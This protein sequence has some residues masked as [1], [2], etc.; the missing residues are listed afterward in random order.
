MAGRTNW[1]ANHPPACTCVRCERNRA[2]DKR[3]TRRPGRQPRQ[4]YRVEQPDTR[5]TSGRPKSRR[6]GS[7]GGRGW[8]WAV[9]IVALLAFL[10]WYGRDN[11]ASIVS[12]IHDTAAT[13]NPTVEPS[14][15]AAAAIA[16]TRTAALST[17]YTQATVEA[18]VQSPVEALLGTPTP[19]QLIVAPTPSP[20][21]MSTPTAVPTPWLQNT[22]TLTPTPLSGGAPTPTMVS[23]PRVRTST[24][25]TATSISLPTV[26]PSPV[27]AGRFRPTT[28]PT[29]ARAAATPTAVPPSPAPTPTPT[30]ATGAVSSL[31]DFENGRWLEQQDP[32]LA[33]SIKEL[34]WIQ[35]GI[36]DMEA[37]AIQDLIYIAVV[38]TRF[39]EVPALV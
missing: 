36:E 14:T 33:A 24:P 23:T 28:T 21:N 6:T 5:F 22:P 17:P 27:W 16:P 20:K 38:K 35:D 30:T 2:I 39:E 1:Y 31:R 3:Q 13:R 32:P 26:T 29:P 8:L 18:Q 10:I 4:P 19:A 34:D 9:L 11:L 25:P 12:D 15:A 7:G 37:K